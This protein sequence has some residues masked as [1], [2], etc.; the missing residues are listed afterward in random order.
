MS[1]GQDYLRQIALTLQQYGIVDHVSEEMIQQ[2]S[3]K[4]RELLA[5]EEDGPVEMI[6]SVLMVLIPPEPDRCVSYDTE[7][8][9]GSE[10]YA[11]LVLEY[12]NATQS[13]WTPE[14]V[15]SA[16]IQIEEG[17]VHEVIDFDFRGQHFHWQFE[18]DGSDWVNIAFVDLLE[19][20]T[21]TWLNGEF[22][23]ICENMQTQ[24]VLFYYLPHQA[25]ADLTTIM[26]Q[27]EQECADL[28]A[29]VKLL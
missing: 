28:A 6:L 27:I 20:F 2:A 23:L 21:A 3:D 8:V 24:N 26:E 12:A 16:R 7:Y 18:A 13:E 15:T 29:F 25:V 19:Q 22:L 17:L 1:K 9:E 4:L 10:D 14:H 11:R 5:A